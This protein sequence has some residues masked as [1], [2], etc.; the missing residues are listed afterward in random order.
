MQIFKR[1][2][3]GLATMGYLAEHT[4]D[5]WI[6]SEIIADKYGVPKDCLRQGMEGLNKRNISRSKAGPGGGLR[7]GRSASDIS[8]LEIIEACESPVAHL[9]DLTQIT[10]DTPLTRNLEKVCR[11]ASDKAVSILSKATL[12]QMVKTIPRVEGESGSQD[13]R[14]CCGPDLRHVVEAWPRLSKELRQAI[15]KMVT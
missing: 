3:Y 11:Q 12:G 10:K 7:L 15:V 9:D 6:R 8:L 2:I 13:C 1:A 4:E 5:G 14:R